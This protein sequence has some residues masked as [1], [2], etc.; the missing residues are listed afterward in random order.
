MTPQNWYL[1]LTLSLRLSNRP[2]I[3]NLPQTCHLARPFCLHHRTASSPNARI[4]K[5]WTGKLQWNNEMRKNFI[6]FVKTKAD[7][8]HCTC[9][10]GDQFDP[11][12]F[13]LSHLKTL[14]RDRSVYQ[15]QCCKNGYLPDWIFPTSIR[16]LTTCQKDMPSVWVTQL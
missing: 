12:D 5:N 16:A 10:R 15:I 14:I 7:W 8:W 2:T 11:R 6:Y 9:G 1:G 3:I 13:Q 4:C